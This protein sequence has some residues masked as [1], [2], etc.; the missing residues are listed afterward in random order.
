MPEYLPLVVHSTNALK[1]P[2]L[3]NSNRKKKSPSLKHLW[4]LVTA[5]WNVL[6]SKPEPQKQHPYIPLKCKDCHKK[7]FSMGACI[8]P[9]EEYENHTCYCCKACHRE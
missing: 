8:S 2:R 7:L 6:Y 3:L 4:H 5:R 9:E 1:K